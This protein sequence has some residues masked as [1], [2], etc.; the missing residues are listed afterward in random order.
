MLPVIR[1][2]RFSNYMPEPFAQVR[3]EMDRLFDQA[4]GN[5][6]S[7]A[8]DLTYAACDLWEDSDKVGLEFDLPGLHKD[9][10][11]I[12]VHEG[13][14]H[15]KGERKQ[16]TNGAERRYWVRER[17]AT[18]FERVVTLP[19]GV[20]PNSIEAELKDG[21]LRLTLSKRPDAQPRKVEVRG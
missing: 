12:T 2:N 21:V 20:D 13:R 16:E 4:F 19:D 8:S 1:S 14:L 17:A 10:V 9:D 11:E 18:K 5:V 7:A 15:L 3:S 6:A